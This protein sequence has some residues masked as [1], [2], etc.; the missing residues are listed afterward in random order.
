MS[1]DRYMTCKMVN[2]LNGT[3]ESDPDF[4]LAKVVVAVDVEPGSTTCLHV[5]RADVY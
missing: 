1:S 5:D 3:V 4:I 2:M